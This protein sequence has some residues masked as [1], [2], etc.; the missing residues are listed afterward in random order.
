MKTSTKRIFRLLSLVM[1]LLL[2]LHAI[3]AGGF[4]AEVQNA[5]LEKELTEQEEYIR[6]L[7]EDLENALGMSLSDAYDQLG[8]GT[9]T[10]TDAHTDADAEV[11]PDAE[12]PQSDEIVTSDFVVDDTICGTFTFNKTTQTITLYT[13]NSA[14]KTAYTLVFPGEIDGTKVLSIASGS[15]N[16]AVFSNNQ[17]ITGVTVSEGI[18][19]V[20][21]Y[22][23]YNCSYLKAAEL[24]NGLET[25]GSSAFYSCYQMTLA[26]LP[27]SLTAIG[28]SAFYNCDKLTSLS[29]P[30]SVTSLGQRV[31]QSCSALQTVTLPAGMTE[32]PAYLFYDCTV[33]TAISLPTGLESIGEYA[34]YNCDKLTE[35]DIPD[36][37]TSLGQRA[38]Q[39]CGA[40]QT[41]TLPAGL[42]ELPIYLF[43]DCAAL[44]GISLPTVLKSI[45]NYAF[46]NCAALTGISLPTVLKSIGNYAFSNC[47]KLTSL[48]IPDSVTSLG[49]NVF[50]S[51]DTL[52]SVTLP[53]G[54]TEL[55]GYLF[56]GCK[57][58]TNL[59]L[60]AGLTSIGNFTFKNCTALDLTAQL[61]ASTT[62]TTIGSNAFEGSGLTGTVVVPAS[63]TSLG[64]SAFQKCVSLTGFDLSVSTL[65]SVPT[66]ICSGC[67][68]LKDI[69][70][71]ARITTVGYQSFKDTKA[72]TAVTIP[73]SVTVIDGYAFQNCSA[74]SSVTFENGQRASLTVGSSAFENCAFT[75]L[76]LPDIGTGYY[77]LSSSAFGCSTAG[78]GKLT[79]LTV[80]AHD[81]SSAKTR[82]DGPFKNQPLVNVTLP[83]GITL[84]TE[85]LFE[86]SAIT[87][88]S[89]L[90]GLLGQITVIG[91]EAF[92]DCASLTAIPDWPA[93]ET[94]SDNAFNGCGKLLTVGTTPALTSIG[95][96]AFS[97]CT[98]LTATPD[99]STVKV[100]GSQTFYN[101]DALTELTLY[102]IHDE[103]GSGIV[104]GCD[105]L[106]T[107]TFAEIPT[108]TDK[109][110]I[111]DT[112]F[113]GNT[114]ITTVNFPAEMTALPREL[115]CSA[116][117]VKDLSFLPARITQYGDG[118]FSSSS[119]TE[120]T[121]P[122]HITHVGEGAFNNCSNLNSLTVLC[123]SSAFAQPEGPEAVPTDPICWFRK[124]DFTSVSNGA[125]N[126]VLPESWTE[127][128]DGMFRYSSITDIGF[129]RAMPALRRIGTAAFA[130][131]STLTGD[132]ETQTLTIPG[133]VTTIGAA[134]FYASLEKV[135]NL[136][137]PRSVTTLERE[138]D[139]VLTARHFVTTSYYTQ[140]A[141]IYIYNPDLDLFVDLFNYTS[142]SSGY[143]PTLEEQ[144]FYSGTRNTLTF[145]AP[146][147][148][149][150][151]AL[152]QKAAEVGAKFEFLE[153]ETAGT[154][155]VTV[156]LP[157]GTDVT[158]RCTISWTD[159]SDTP[160]G[161][162]A[163]L[164][165]P[166][167]NA[168]YTYTVTPDETLQVLYELPAP[169]TVISSK[170]ELPITVTLTERPRVTV[171]SAVT[172]EAGDPLQGVSV[173]AVQ[174]INGI[175]VVTGPVLTGADGTFTIAIPEGEGYLSFAL[176]G[177]ITEARPCSADPGT[178]VLKELPAS[179]V[180]FLLRVERTGGGQEALQ[181]FDGLELEIT[182]ALGDPVDHI[183]QGQTLILS[184]AV[185]MNEELTLRVTGVDADSLLAA[186]LQ[187]VTF[188]VGDGSVTVVLREQGRFRLH[189]DNSTDGYVWLFDSEGFLV[190]TDTLLSRDL[191]SA[192]LPAGSYTVAVVEKSC[193]VRNPSTLSMLDELGLTEEQYF[194]SAV[195]ITDGTLSEISG[196]TVPALSQEALDILYLDMFESFTLSM[197]PRQP[198]AGQNYY[199][200]VEYALKEEYRG[201]ENKTVAVYLPAETRFNNVSLPFATDSY[202]P[203]RGAMSTVLT[204]TTSADEGTIHL[205]LQTLKA[206]ANAACT[207]VLSTGAGTASPQTYNYRVTDIRII[208][209]STIT[210]PGPQAV[211][212]R[213]MPHAEVTLYLDG[214]PVG[215]AKAN[216]AGTA[217][218]SVEMTYP[219][220]VGRTWALTADAVIETGVG[221]PVTVTSATPKTITFARDA[222]DPVLKTTGGSVFRFNDPGSS[223]GTLIFGNGRKGTLPVWEVSVKEG[224]GKYIKDG[225][226]YLRLTDNSQSTPR[227]WRLP[228]YRVDG[229]D[230]T[231]GDTFVATF[232]TPEFDAIS[233]EY[234]V[235]E[236]Y[237]DFLATQPVYIDEASVDARLE[238]VREDLSV[239]GEDVLN[240]NATGLAD[241][242]D[243]TVLAVYEAEL[244][245]EPDDSWMESE[246]FTSM[247]PEEQEA[248][249]KLE[250]ESKA[251]R[252]AAEDRLDQ[253]IEDLGSDVDPDSSDL[254]SDL[255]LTSTVLTPEELQSHYDSPEGL[256]VWEGDHWVKV[257]SSDYAQT[258]VDSRNS[259]MTVFDLSAY[260][261]ENPVSLSR[262]AANRADPT[263]DP[264][265]EYDFLY[266]NEDGSYE[267]PP[268][269]ELPTLLNPQTYATAM[270][271]ASIAF[272]SLSTALSMEMEMLTQIIDNYGPWLGKLKTAEYK[273]AVA[274]M[275]FLTKFTKVI[276]V[277][278]NLV[279]AG[280]F[281]RLLVKATKVY[282]DWQENMKFIE[283]IAYAETNPDPYRYSYYCYYY[284]TELDFALLD[285]AG[286]LMGQMASIIAQATGSLAC[287]AGVFATGGLTA[288]GF[289][290]VQLAG[291]VVDSYLGVA[292]EEAQMIIKQTEKFKKQWCAEDTSGDDDDDDDEPVQKIHDPSGYVYEAV[293]S[294]RVEGA[295]VTTY[296][297]EDDGTAVLWDAE[298]YDQQNPLITD[299]EGFYAW[300]VPEDEWKVVA[301]KEGYKTTDTT[302]IYSQTHMR[303]GRTDIT[304][305]GWHEVLPVQLEVHIPMEST[306]APTV[307]SAVAYGDGIGIRFSQ[308]MKEETVSVTVTQQ[309]RTFSGSELELV[310]TDSELSDHYYGRT[311]ASRLTVLRADGGEWEG[312]VTLTVNGINYAGTAMTS[313]S[314]TLEVLS[315]P[316]AI[317]VPADVW[318]RH[319]CKESVTLTVT[320]RNGTA[321]KGAQVAATSADGY[322]SAEVSGVTDEN[323]R[324]TLTV[325]GDFVGWDSL[326]LS[327]V[328]REGETELP[329][330]VYRDAAY[331]T[332]ITPCVI[333]DGVRYTG[334][335]HTVTV[336]AGTPISVVGMPG[337]ELYYSYGDTAAD[338]CPCSDGQI[339][340]EDG[341][342][343]PEE[344]GYYKFAAY[345]GGTY[346]ERVHIT[347]TV[348][349]APQVSVV[350][351]RITVTHPTAGADDPLDMIIVV[352]SYDAYGRMT[353]CQFI[354]D[355]TGLTE[356]ELTVS[357]ELKVFF[358]QPGTLIPLF[359][360]VEP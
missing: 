11:T 244:N 66:Y 106:T 60:P 353:G 50:Q 356:A 322:V 53:A 350:G 313:R 70:L 25:I 77:A 345:S 112:A 338:N 76:T 75:A 195:I 290:L 272:T 321:V 102:A 108:F 349:K 23:F 97:N 229:E 37:V 176:E 274:R 342:V 232:S 334:Q 165:P 343:V 138:G 111:A 251:K 333:I 35:L 261:A 236:E 360:C 158:D 95:S 38:F 326:R 220:F 335:G 253:L 129:L 318:V 304:A 219:F 45:G 305:D 91:K 348:V 307:D 215:T 293:F 223:P 18:T 124:V 358:L 170:E 110:Y 175:E 84:I 161:T 131:I 203:D 339:L 320:D 140:L 119:I 34:F 47:D 88:L 154:I 85:G 273:H 294:N 125:P 211:V 270:D 27:P 359:E 89:F 291:L 300:F 151:L 169:A 336:P 168:S 173:T 147:N 105:K 277:L 194:R 190:Y 279:Q 185:P 52:Q 20:G 352:A 235:T 226:V 8:V 82:C 132:A 153:L 44:T 255:G 146:L 241:L 299:G 283:K 311:F 247:S 199:I 245:A 150:T 234:D 250:E 301:E 59:I 329:V 278:A 71:S 166:E 143:N 315:V 224:Y 310:W 121:I 86:R 83:A 302:D 114:T 13:H 134:A 127:I 271:N 182:N 68:A 49:Q 204:I 180:L 15:N 41:V 101:C 51:C 325:S 137:I 72:L 327:L 281:A 191:L 258:I 240:P 156:T 152:C 284:A 26:D 177:Y 90:S 268:P 316:A 242:L 252:L 14:V 231:P 162:G 5:R 256:L 225:V 206:D 264:E 208:T 179:T 16:R 28:D 276:P 295:T 36:S 1:A 355:V 237:F 202:V 178:V 31:F 331:T 54:M 238:S 188:R 337:Q 249:L 197:T 139:S 280:N 128:P 172:D 63:V 160:L 297:R 209:G 64:S 212:I 228:L 116:G 148:S 319:G 213:T 4:A 260:A 171:T 198:L 347:I 163:A 257:Y 48:S 42:T 222:F 98:K 144:V 308:Y 117:F 346:S 7:T 96:S 145:H 3:P 357:G 344:S 233:L 167:I 33:L 332:P 65:T 103:V 254:L 341:T 69:T 100:I 30:D 164:T 312:S 309:G 267:L 351:G 19:S 183:L 32:L 12:A 107:L 189:S 120:A 81:W 21:N 142:S 324:V 218:L 210:S 135:I 275:T 67:T 40:L 239:L 181:D 123:P 287:A 230:G 55:P 99:L 149:T 306:G 122:A 58:L 57:S 2:A 43:S 184:E 92:R 74:L 289:L 196:F 62:L 80:G 29:I 115:F 201:G 126:I 22:A 17:Y 73:A 141:H 46:S 200:T 259:T 174:T 187:P 262:S 136:V 248:L 87:D 266:D 155:T 193:P 39:S 288:I 61:N 130:D 330:T 157:D 340:I 317:D 24:P 243:P 298:D 56:E 186:P 328:G 10:D 94:I 109:T 159:G 323:G 78:Q 314:E 9:N 207:V 282:D 285:Y 93:L 246:A 296:Y 303:D 6:S 216:S 221:D 104:S 205:S 292:A 133:T 217:Q 79:T 265:E 113:Q 227:V 269:Y 214:E 263:S 118:C 354:T 286:I 192:P